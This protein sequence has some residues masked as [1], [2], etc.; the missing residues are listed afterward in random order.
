MSLALRHQRFLTA[1]RTAGVSASV[2]E[3][4]DAVAALGLVGW[5]DREVV[6]ETYAATLVKRAWHREAFDS[7]FDIHFPRAAGAATSGEGAG[8]GSDLDDVRSRVVKA[9]AGEAAPETLRALAVE[10]LDGFGSLPGRGT[11]APTWSAHAT[12]GRIDAAVL[13]DR[14]LAALGD[15]SAGVREREWAQRRVRDFTR[16]VEAEARRRLAESKGPE[17]VARTTVRP[18]IDRLDFLSATNAELA[19][20]R[21]EVAPLARRL[22]V[23]LAQRRRSRRRGAV[24][25]RRTVR[26]AVGTGGVPVRLHHRVREPRRTDLVVLCDVS[27]SVANFAGFTLSLLQALGDTF[28]GVRAFTFID[29]VSEVTSDLRARED[30]AGSMAALVA[31]AAHAA[32]L[33]RTDHGRAF[34]RFLEMHGDALGPRTSLLILG[35]ARSGGVTAAASALATMA[36]G[37]RN[38]WWL[39]PEHRVHWDTGD[40]AAGTY[41]QIVE[42]SE[43]RNL[44]QLQQFVA[45]IA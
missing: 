33:G 22:A 7:L 11:G 25:M 3:G 31:S 44:R 14:L 21:A 4:L 6:R 28:S 24:D 2:A 9:L 36:G 15:D 1:L 10:A 13:V 5:E 12:N 18:S 35:D 40:S 43:C 41:G 26:S 16:Q 17:H 29:D 42:M 32:R 34:T 27:G 39:N 20:L 45:S 19:A 23:R 38:A 37:V 30:P 8:Q